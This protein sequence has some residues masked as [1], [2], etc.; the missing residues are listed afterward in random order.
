MVAGSDDALT[1]EG[2]EMTVDELLEGVL[3]AVLTNAEDRIKACG[4][5]AYP[6]ELRG[7]ALN[8][9]NS[10][11]ASIYAFLLCLSR[12]GKDAVPGENGAKLFEDVCAYAAANYLGCL[13]AP[14][15][16]YVFGFPRRIGP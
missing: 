13:E 8:S 2:E 4:E 6:F 9:K 15:E 16:K 1:D 14:A 5:D 7:K 10:A 11:F 12:Y 3:D